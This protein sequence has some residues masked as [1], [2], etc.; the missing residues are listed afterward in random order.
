MTWQDF[1]PK[2]NGIQKSKMSLMTRQVLVQN[3][4]PF[5]QCVQLLLILVTGAD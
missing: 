2:G 1:L 5:A 4:L 3:K